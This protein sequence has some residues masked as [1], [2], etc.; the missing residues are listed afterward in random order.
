MVRGS[1]GANGLEGVFH[2]RDLA[3]NL[4]KV[5]YISVFSMGVKGPTFRLDMIFLEV[6][7][8]FAVDSAG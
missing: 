1:D 6:I 7:A 2:D 8:F 5:P 3:A 4:R